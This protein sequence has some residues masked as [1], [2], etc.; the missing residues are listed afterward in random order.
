MK[1]LDPNAN[2]DDILNAT[3]ERWAK[4]PNKT[5]IKEGKQRLTF[6]MLDGRA[7][8][9]ARAFERKGAISGDFIGYVGPTGIPFIVTFFAC[10]KA[11]LVFMPISPKFPPMSIAAILRTAEARFLVSDQDLSDAVS[12]VVAMSLPKGDVDPMPFQAPILPETALVFASSTSGS[13]GIP[14]IIAHERCGIVGFIKQ[15][16]VNTRVN[17]DSILGHAGTTWAVMILSALLVG[18]SV[19]CYDVT[20]GTPQDLFDWLA[21]DKVTYWFV[22]PALFRTLAQTKG[23]LPDLDTLM[24]C[25]EQVFRNDFELFERLTKPGAC[26]QNLYAQQEFL[27]ATLFSIRNGERLL[28]EKI[29]AGRPAPDNDLCISGPDG[30]PVG[31]RGIGEIVQRSARIPPGYVGNPERTANVFSTGAGGMR[32]FATG[33]LGYFDGD[34]TLHIVGRK[35]DQIKIRSFN[36]QPTDIEQEI[37]PH[38][39]IEAV[40][41]TVSY[42]SRGLPRLACYYEGGVA[43]ADLKAWLS[44]RVP[45][46]MMPQ[47][48]IPMEA[49][50]RT[51]TGKLQRNQLVLPEDLSAAHRVLANTRDEKILAD[52]W[53]QVLGHSDFGMSDNFFDVGG[54]SLRGMELLLLINQQFGRLLTLD[55]MI[56]AGGT[57]QALVTLLQQPPEHSHLMMLKP[58]TGGPH[59]VA[60]HVYGGGV[61]DYLEIAQAIGGDIKVSGICADYSQRNRAYNVRKKA[62]EAVSHIP[63]EPAPVMMGYS[64]GARIAFEIAHL[65][66]GDE[67]IILID[68][69]GPFSDRWHERLKWKFEALVRR[70]PGLGM[71]EAYPGDYSYKPVRLKTKGALFVACDTSYEAD[72]AGW[73]EIIDGPVEVL[74]LPGGHFNVVR[75]ANALEIARR[76]QLWL[77]STSD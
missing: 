2:L 35:D 60:G 37:K 22:Y 77:A 52:I 46:F 43:P 27:Y 53:Q 26:F 66:D 11:G 49:L 19:A 73:A 44:E 5:A 6:A 54:D 23:V 65:L 48:F 71:E 28:Y 25:G 70:S 31:A 56:M 10:L 64:Y 42:C 39:Q 51:P 63:T 47:F 30:K 50:P 16:L 58:G 1:D 8:H 12:G 9:M 62:Q 68:P 13:T 41:V 18:A 75:G 29:P 59:I 17:E 4:T 76:V 24:L 33:D 3:A 21:S 69:R 74:R 14:K 61:S 20:Q 40:A 32:N 38:P 72:I 67:R 45:A 15:D 57:I 34:G 36:V 55:K 7:N